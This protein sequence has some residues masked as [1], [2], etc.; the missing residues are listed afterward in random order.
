MYSHDY[1]DS[2]TKFSDDKLPDRWEFLSSLENGCISEKDY[3]PVIDIWNMLGRKKCDYHHIYLKTDVLL[4]A[5]VFVKFINTCLEYYRLDLRHY[6]RYPELSWNAMLKM[7]DIELELIS[8]IDMYSFVKIGMRGGISY[9]AKKYSKA[10]NKDI[11]SHY[12]NNKSSKYITYLDENSLYGWE[13][14]QYFPYS[15]FKWLNQ[16]EIDKCDKM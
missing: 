1:V 6:F 5:D 15:K 8:D 13:M 4:L 2:F 14:S 10:N 11:K 7:T 9:I 3:L 16:K 12:D